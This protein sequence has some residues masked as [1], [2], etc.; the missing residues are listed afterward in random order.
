MPSRANP[1]A[2]ESLITVPAQ[3]FRMGDDSQWA[4][5]ADGEGPVHEV[6]LSAFQ[7]D[8]Y[9]VTNA[10]FAEFVAATGWRTDA[11]KY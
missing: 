6:S 11:E 2:S 8:R 7:L 4:Y 3:T 1:T 5:P 10:R 9:A